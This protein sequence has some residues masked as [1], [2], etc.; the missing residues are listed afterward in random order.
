[1]LPAAPCELTSF[2]NWMPLMVTL[3]AVACEVLSGSL[4]VA[5]PSTTLT[6]T[7]FCTRLVPDVKGRYTRPALSD[8]LAIDEPGGNLKKK[9]YFT[10]WYVFQ[11]EVTTVV[12]V[13]VAVAGVPV[14]VPVG[15]AVGGPG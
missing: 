4:H 13:A 14:G 11:P 2:R 12:G 1:M 9:P 5:A 7:Y 10:F 8:W 3:V 15:G 6:S